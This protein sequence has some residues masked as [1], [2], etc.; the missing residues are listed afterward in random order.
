LKHAVGPGRRPRHLLSGI[1]RCADCGGPIVVV[2]RYRYGCSTHKERGEAA[3]PN[4]LK[5][6]Q[7]PADSTMLEFIRRE[8]LSDAAFKAAQRAVRARLSSR[9]SDKTEAE[10]ALAD[11]QRLHG[12]IMDALRQ[13]IIT[14]STRALLIEAEAAVESAKQA[15][16]AVAVQ[17][18]QI[19]PQLRA[20]WRR[21]V[22][23][24]DARSH[25][26]AKR[27]VLQELFGEMVLRQEGGAVYAEAGTSQIKMVAGAGFERYL[28]Q[29]VVQIPFP[30]GPRKRPMAG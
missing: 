9:G 27:A 12:N 17:P 21:L 29:R 23:S 20:F 13:G 15:L 3:C 4:A 26:V 14:P 1:L 8:L 7:A 24:M 22:E 10:R 18:A 2:D 11:A 16:Q 28:T 5:I 19:V 25:S 6:A 30:T